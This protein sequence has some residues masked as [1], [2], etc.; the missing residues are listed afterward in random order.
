MSTEL[1]IGPIAGVYVGDSALTT[2]LIKV[3]SRRQKGSTI[4]TNKPTIYEPYDGKRKQDGDLVF[5]FELTFAGTT[6]ENLKLAFG[7]LPNAGSLD[8]GSNI[9]LLSMFLLAPDRRGPG[10]F[11]FPE[12]SVI[13]QFEIPKGELPG[14]FKLAFEARS[15]NWHKTLITT[16]TVSEIFALPAYSSRN[17]FGS[18]V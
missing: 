13:S 9:T 8:P 2:A 11:Y 3:R 1:T 4:R 10:S 14:G 16:G 7:Q 5:Q 6:Q 15:R 17:P 18:W 12:I